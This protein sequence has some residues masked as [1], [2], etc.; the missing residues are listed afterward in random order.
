MSI[1]LKWEGDTSGSFIVKGYFFELE[2]DSQISGPAN[3]LWNSVPTKM[4]FFA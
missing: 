1:R 3:L 4:R 2:G